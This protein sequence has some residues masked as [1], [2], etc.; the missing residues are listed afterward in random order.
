MPGQPAGTKKRKDIIMT[1]D[2]TSIDDITESLDHFDSEDQISVGELVSAR[3]EVID[4]YLS[5]CKSCDDVGDTDIEYHISVLTQVK[6]IDDN[7][8]HL[9]HHT[10]LVS[11]NNVEEYIREHIENEFPEA[12]EYAQ[13]Y[14]SSWPMNHIEFDIDAAIEEKVSEAEDITISGTTFYVVDLSY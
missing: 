11:E 4:K 3:N 1:L 7:V 6:N 13:G 14:Y 9:S 8:G 5:Y 12:A 10:E 2:T